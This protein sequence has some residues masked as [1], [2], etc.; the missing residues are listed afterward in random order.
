MEENIIYIFG[1][2]YHLE[3]GRD[4]LAE[5]IILAFCLT[6]QSNQ[7][8]RQQAIATNIYIY[9]CIY[10]PSVGD[11][12]FFLFFSWLDLSVQ[13]F[14]SWQ[15]EQNY[16]IINVKTQHIVNVTIFVITLLVGDITFCKYRFPESQTHTWLSFKHKTEVWEI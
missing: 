15:F 9:V 8:I 14:L 7:H 3:G 6:S 4:A 13:N 2:E 12:F 16:C 11:S 10:L 1:W 5:C